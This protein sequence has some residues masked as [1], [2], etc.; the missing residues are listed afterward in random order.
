MR[1]LLVAFALATGIS[2]AI[3]QTPAIDIIIFG[4]QSSASGGGSTGC[5]NQLTLVYTNSC[6][7]IAVTNFRLG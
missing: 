1:W 5:T 6:A 7:I 4:K 3:A 2:A